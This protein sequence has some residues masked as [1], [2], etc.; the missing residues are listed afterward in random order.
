MT[1]LVTLLKASFY[2]ELLMVISAFLAFLIGIVHRKKFKELRFM[3]LYA[4]SSIIQI[5]SLYYAIFWNPDVEFYLESVTGNIFILIESVV[6]Y[7]F[8]SKIIIIRSLKT[9][10]NILFTAFGVYVILLWSFT[11]SFYNYPARLY[12]PQAFCIL[13]FCFLYFFQLFR[14]PPTLLLL[15]NPTFWVATGCLFFFSCTIPLFFAEVMFPLPTRIFAINYF[16]YSI[17]F[18]LIAKSFLCRPAQVK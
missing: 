1:D 7:N 12:L 17:L 14:L 6:L 9:V 5:S 10:V 13:T 4:L 16:A 15:T 8:F 2:T 11:S 18:L 3:P